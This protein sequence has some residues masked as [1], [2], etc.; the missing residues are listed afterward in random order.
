[1]WLN[2]SVWALTVVGFL[3]LWQLGMAWEVS[4]S[5][6]LG[7]D[8]PVSQH[9][10]RACDSEGDDEDE[11]E[12]EGE[13]DDKPKAAQDEGEDDDDEDESEEW[14]SEF[15]LQKDDLVST[16]RNPYFILE[17]GYQLTLEGGGETVV[18]TV[19]NETKTVDGIET[20]VVEERESKNGKLVEV[21]RNF[22]AL[23]KRTNCVFYFGEEVDIYKDGKVVKHEGAWLAGENKARAGLAMPGLPLLGAK[24]YQEFAPKVAMD[25]A[26]I[27]E[28]DEEVTTPAGK[29][30]DCLEVEETTPL[31]P[32]EEES[33]YYAPGVGL[34][35]DGSLKL[36][37]YGK[38]ELPK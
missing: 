28:L 13:D 17:P 31:E 23:S 30:E 20:R 37:K 9:V 2:G 14:T 27:E 21:S 36:V 11:A 35:R 3:G 15:S 16:G 22:F 8:A 32:G 33:K 5:A 6:L 29:F 25:R 4:R 26:E 19:T 12:D 1:M 34:V 7:R 18:I 10:S 38:V 24:Y